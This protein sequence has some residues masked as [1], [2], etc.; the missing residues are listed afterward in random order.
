MGPGISRPRCRGAQVNP[1]TV[2][3]S[4]QADTVGFLAELD[5]VTVTTPEPLVMP[6]TVSVN[7]PLKETVTSAP[8]IGLP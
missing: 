8:P 6:E 4:T 7:V 5:V 1:A 2:K 3:A